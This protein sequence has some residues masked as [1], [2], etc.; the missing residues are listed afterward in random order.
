MLKFIWNAWWRNKERF[1]LLLVGVLIVSTG[2]SYLIGT[3]QANKGTVVDAL[4]Q[5][6]HSS[7]DIVVRPV[8]S[9]S[10]TED[11]KLLE[12]N[13]MSGLDGGITRKQYETIKQMTDVEVAAPI[14]MIG[15]TYIGTPIGTHTIKKQGIYRLRINSQQD[16][17]LKT[18]QYITD[19]YLGAG[20]EPL[21]DATKTGLSPLGVGKVPL[22][23]Q[24]TYEMIAG[25]DPEAEAR[26]VGLKDAVH[27]TAHSRYFDPNTK[28]T[29]RGDG[30]IQIP[31]LL[32]EQ[33]YSTVKTS[34]TYED[35]L[36]PL[37]DDSMN[38]TVNMIE[39][40][41]GRE[42]LETLKT[43]H[44]KTYTITSRQIRKQLVTDILNGNHEPN[45]ASEFD[46]VSQKPSPVKYQPL[47]SPFGNRWPY[48]YQVEP[49]RVEAES[50]LAKRAMYRK[51]NK[52]GQT[53]D[54]WIKLDMN[55][56]GVFNA[57]K[58]KLSKD[59]LTELPMETY[60]PAK[61]QWVMDAQERPVNPPRDVEAMDDPFDF[62]TKPPSVLT[63]LDAAFAIRGDKAISAIR[64]H[65]KGVETLNE[66]SE[67]K[68]QAVAREIEDKTGLITDVTLG[69]SPQLALTYL[70]GLDGKKALGWIQQPWIKLGSSISIFEEAKVGMGGV[71]ASVIA[72]AIVY[73][74]SSNIIL[75]YARKKE[76]AILLSLG[77]RP[78]QL[79]T[80]LLLEATLLGILV[81]LIAWLILGGF[82]LIGNGGT[83]PERVLLVGLAGLLIYWG[84]TLVPMALIR[85][86]RPYET[87]RAGEATSGRRFVRSTGVLGMSLNQ[88]LTYWQR[89]VLSIIAI[90]LPTSLFMFFLFVTFRLKGVLYATWL[91]EFV[92]LEV[93]TMH[94]IA[95]GVALLIAILT[96]TEI[97]WQ[98]V[99]ER[100]S[101]LAVLKVTGW[102]D[103]RIRLLVLIEGG[104]TGLL[105]GMIG[106]A[107]ALVLIWQTYHTFPTADIGFL[108]LTLMIPLAT[109]VVGALLP[110]ARAVRITPSAAI[111]QTVVNS[112]ATEKRFKIALGTIGGGLVASILIL[113]FF[114]VAKIP[115]AP[116]KPVTKPT[117][118]IQTTGAKL[119]DQQSQKERV[120]P[121][122]KSVKESNET[123]EAVLQ[124]A[125]FRTYPGDTN[126][127]RYNDLEVKEARTLT[128]LK[129]PAG[130]KAIMIRIEMQDSD[131]M[132]VGSFYTY[133]PQFFTLTNDQSGTHDPIDVINRNPKAWIEQSKYLP[134]YK[135]RV[136]LIYHVPKAAKKAVLFLNGEWTAQT[137]AFEMKIK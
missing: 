79:S 123:L 69:S 71:I 137:Y 105:A 114:V 129:S 9:R 100:K 58:L 77:W 5:R 44:P 90:A 97:L 106:L 52:F 63:T 85:W 95:M 51:P 34:Y 117:K 7:Y 64:I 80:L 57:K 22:Y 30:A 99:N 56:I 130:Q 89:T 65:V 107:V 15:G 108:C 132:V 38:A 121:K 20:W 2:L 127:K 3:S 112:K 45:G 76:F 55:Y 61:A 41:G 1:I 6:W 122:K 49:Q 21:K 24:G 72:V 10:V 68:L 47:K 62:L 16:T 11:L 4:Q 94:Y 60:F 67:A 43:D 124:K 26:L 48:T 92:A 109:G 113:G 74:F 125:S 50:L 103:R 17:G 87:M 66:Q 86:I 14:A 115:P 84:G 135:S 37:Q 53:S 27:T 42:F 91:G 83:S 29:K 88:L 118:V 54:D 82:S 40:K 101:Q 81:T 78:R 110:A 104:L 96:T 19:H 126:V 12:P 116:A 111:N 119:H 133:E 102:H 23:E 131:E 13:Y 18:E 120:L 73:V 46:W 59:P 36:L 134:P 28:I 70:P 35:V 31:V 25:V 8:G 33:E 75:L 128:N 93:G 39:Q 98:N 32:N 136:D